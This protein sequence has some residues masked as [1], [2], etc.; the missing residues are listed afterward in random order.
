LEEIIGR[1]V[2]LV[3]VVL[4]YPYFFT[5]VRHAS[6][7]HPLGI[8]QVAA[9]L[10]REG[11]ET[12]VLDCTFRRYED[13]VGE[14]LDLRPKITGISVMLT[15]AEKAISLA[16]E[17]RKNL[18]GTLLV[19]GGPLPTVRPEWFA[20]HFHLIFRGEAVMPFSTFCRD[21]LDGRCRVGRGG[22]PEIPLL[23]RYPGIY[24]RPAG[25]AAESVP[26]QSLGEEEINL[27]P[28]PDRG[29]YDH[30]RYQRFWRGKG[31][32]L[33]AGIMTTYGCPQDCD[34][35][36][37]PVF[38]R[39]FRRRNIDS[40]MREIATIK[41]LGYNGMRIADDSFLT[42][43]S[44]MRTLC[45]RMIAEKTEMKWTCLARARP[46][47]DEDIRLMAN[48]GC[49]KV[50]LGLES[51]DDA[52]LR[53]MNKNITVAEA[54]EAVG[55]FTRNGIAAAGYFMV[56]Y[57]GESR[58]SVETTLRWAVSLPLAEA[59]FTLPFPL[60][61]TPLYRRVTR[62]NS[63]ADWSYE[64]ENRLIFDSDIAETW[65]RKKIEETQAFIDSRKR[66]PRD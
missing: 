1:K 28:L 47:A 10:R 39:H 35:C 31:Q 19:C 46:I 23:D 17:T 2:L 24:R 30:G 50:Y 66:Q 59:S 62:V 13:V 29:D 15:M 6:P 26:R 4:I 14:L 65:L 25:G 36:S 44:H 63:E 64:N 43:L 48:A 33:P 22:V 58:A 53:M 56:G 18:P 38:G 61:G 51:G 7:Y 5:G 40:I 11:I 49:S 32:F 37:R 55:A 27:L 21:I 41:S 8:A 45:R 16:R 9:N 42:D 52:T 34:F 54:E 60:P 3:D 57:P 20:R 12:V